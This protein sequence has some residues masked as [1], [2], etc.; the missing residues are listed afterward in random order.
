MKKI[1]RDQIFQITFDQQ[2][3]EVIR[4]CQQIRRKGQYGTWIT[5]RM[6]DAYYRLHQ[7]GFAHSVEVWK[8]GELAGGLYGVSIGKCYY[9]ES[10]FSKVSNA[11]K[12]GFIIL[13]QELIKRDFMLVDCQV[14]TKHLESL[15]ANEIPR[16]KFSSI[17]QEAVSHKTHLGNWEHWLMGQST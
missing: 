1:L 13:V 8:D 3:L 11:S 15:G 9:G 6:L 16:A 4:Q 12:A 17:L 5:P 2:F 10:M 14:Y 7:M